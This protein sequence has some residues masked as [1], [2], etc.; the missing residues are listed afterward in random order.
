MNIKEIS[1]RLFVAEQI[2][3][4]DVAVAAAQ[5]VKTI[6]CNRPDSEAAD[7]PSSL[8][9][10]KAASEHGMAFVYVPVVSGSITDDNVRDFTLAYESAIEPILAYCKSGMRST[11]LWAMSEASS[12]GVDTVLATAFEAGYDLAGLRLRLE[13]LAK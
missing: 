11:C 9:I 3:A 10:A 7:Q 1:P 5:G 8:E 13:S 4:G 2:T 6:I 12:Q